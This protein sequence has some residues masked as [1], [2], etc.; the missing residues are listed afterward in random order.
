MA[1]PHVSGAFGD[2]L[3]VDFEDIFNDTYDQLPDKVPM[4]FTLVPHNGQ[5]HM[6][7]SEIGTVP[8]I[9][10]TSEVASLRSADVGGSVAR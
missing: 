2:L 5:N 3:D 6:R 7:W 9:S 1:V 4:I 10:R 8:N